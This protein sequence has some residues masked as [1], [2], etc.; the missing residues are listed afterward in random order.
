MKYIYN[1]IKIYVVCLCALLSIFAFC[2]C[3][4][5]LEENISKNVSEYR[6]NFFLGLGENFSATFTDGQRESEFVANGEKT[7][8]VDFGVIVIKGQN[9]SQKN[10]SLTINNEKISGELEITPFDNTLV[11]DIKKVVDKNDQLTLEYLGEKVTLVCLS[12]D[13]KINYNNALDIF[14]H[15]NKDTLK[16]YNNT[17]NFDG[18]IYIKLV[19]DKQ[20]M[21]NI[22]YYV[23]CITKNGNV[24]ATLID[25][26]N[27]E[28]LQ[29]SWFCL[30]QK[31]YPLKLAKQK[32]RKNINKTHFILISNID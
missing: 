22:Y 26:N 21:S 11:V 9:L 30:N 5:L 2:G 32:L 31:T 1:I 20:D 15:K 19:S 6:Q 12:K 7:S 27:G 8:L 23:L 24:L 29:K 4:V 16:Q 13:W 14:V 3:G 25:V 17:N 18:E 10:F 28:I